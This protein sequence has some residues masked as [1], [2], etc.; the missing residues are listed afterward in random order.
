MRRPPSLFDDLRQRLL[1]LGDRPRV[2]AL[3]CAPRCGREDHRGSWRVV[4]GNHREEERAWSQL[5]HRSC[6]VAPGRDH[7]RGPLH[8][9]GDQARHDLALDQVEKELGRVNEDTLPPLP[10]SAQNR[11]WCSSSLARTG[12]PS[13]LSRSTA[14]RVIA[15]GAVLALEPAGAAAEGE[16]DHAGSWR[17]DQPVPS[18][19]RRRRRGGVDLGPGEE[20]RPRAGR[21]AGSG[22]TST[23][24]IPRRSA[25]TPPSQSEARDRGGHLATDRE[26]QASSRRAKASTGGDVLG[27]GAAKATN[28]G[29]CATIALNSVQASSPSARTGF[30]ADLAAQERQGG[31]FASRR[32]ESSPP[33]SLVLAGCGRH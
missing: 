3:Y 31:L 14:I 5:A 32:W 4:E 27:R 28:S 22:S 29:R 11:S 16:A 7:L 19:A 15:G 9:L 8:R 2:H 18:P 33:P 24:S 21:T 12:R 13:A 23:K 10:R 6:R 26:R 17:P 20:R 25:T 30:Q 1:T